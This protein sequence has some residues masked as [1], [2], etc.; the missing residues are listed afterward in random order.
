MLN[1]SITERPVQ[2]VL[3]RCS[4]TP[5]FLVSSMLLPHNTNQTHKLTIKNELQKDQGGGGKAEE[6]VTVWTK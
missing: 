3:T 2:G 6:G 1:F 5:T 4:R